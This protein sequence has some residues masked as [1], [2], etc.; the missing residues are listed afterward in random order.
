MK[1]RDTRGRSGPP[2]Q[3][4]LRCER[5]GGGE[6]GEGITDNGA[7]RRRASRLGI[8]TYLLISRCKGEGREE[9]VGITLR[10]LGALEPWAPPV[11]HGDGI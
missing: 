8:F 5:F 4:Y 7:G 2:S 3:E 11:F 6:Y 9:F 10:G 1:A